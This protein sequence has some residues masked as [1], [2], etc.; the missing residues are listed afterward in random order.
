LGQGILGSGLEIARIISTFLIALGRLNDHLRDGT[1]FVKN[2]RGRKPP[3]NDENQR[4]L[5]AA[6]DWVE[7]FEM[8]ACLP[9]S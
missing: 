7:L 1:V 4:S 8:K 3:R 9:L 5:H 6:K 2:A